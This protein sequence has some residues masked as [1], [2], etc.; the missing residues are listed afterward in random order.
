MSTEKGYSNSKKY[1]RPQHKTIHNVGGDAYAPPSI[2]KLLQAIS[3]TLSIEAVEVSQ[4]Q[5]LIKITI[6]GHG[7][8]KGETVKFLSGNLFPYDTEIVNVVDANNFV[9][10]NTFGIPV[11]ADTLQIARFSTGVFGSD[12]TTSFIKDGNAQ[13]VTEDNTTPSNNAPLP[14]G[15]YIRKNGVNLPVTDDTDPADD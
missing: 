7:A 9:I 11:I 12:N 2:I 13:V 3:G 4:D 10:F 15:L 8:S 5:K 1:G 6:T 14:S